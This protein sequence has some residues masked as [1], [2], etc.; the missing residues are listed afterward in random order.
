MDSPS[1]GGII[2]L[3][4]QSLRTQIQLEQVPNYRAL[5]VF[6]PPG[7]FM[8][9]NK[10]PILSGGVLASTDP[11]ECL[12]IYDHP[13]AWEGLNRESIL[14][15]RRHLYQ[16]AINVNAR[17][18]QP[19]NTIESLQTI[20]LSVTPVALGVEVTSV[21]PR[22]LHNRGGLL[23]CSPMVQ[24][25]S[26]DVL[27]DPEISNV[28]KRITEK[29]VPASESIWSLLDYDYSLDRVVRLMSVGLLGR[30]ANRRLVPMRSAY[31]AVID[32]FISRAVMELV[33]KPFAY[34]T[35]MY[36]AN[37]FGDTFTIIMQPGEPRVDYVNIELI[38]GKTSRGTS[39]ED[40]R[41]P[42]TD[43]KTSVFADHARFSVYA[44]LVRKKMSCH[45][46]VFHLS[47]DRRNTILGPWIA[48]AGVKKALE[49]SPVSLDTDTN[50][51]TILESVL[52]PDL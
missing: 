33:E 51:Q 20:A 45:V 35:E 11:L 42:D 12:S 22:H 15:M 16:F 37:L 39:F 50:V 32:S 8:Q 38:G 41:Y 10:Y 28:A 49:T 34:M 6:S 17:D 26:I 48:R 9:T 4:S 2:T 7:I 25:K 46:I 40:L 52:R 29:D 14:S 30:L 19:R 36:L 44:N 1:A 5:T 43:P 18:M 27:S 24:V 47:Q 21:P 13:E 23:P 3:S 31:K